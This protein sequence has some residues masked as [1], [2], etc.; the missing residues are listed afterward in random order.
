[1]AWKRLPVWISSKHLLAESFNN[2]FSASVVKPR[3]SG[4]STD[5]NQSH[6]S[7]DLTESVITG[8][9]LLSCNCFEDRTRPFVNCLICSL[10]SLLQVERKSIRS[11]NTSR[12]T[13]MNWPKSQFLQLS[14]QFLSHSPLLCSHDVVSSEQARLSSSH[15]K[16]I[17]ILFHLRLSLSLALVTVKKSPFDYLKMS[18][19]FRFFV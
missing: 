2:R 11:T 9:L 15:S 5:H 4:P 18:V 3:F 1:V 12:A 7:S 19:S 17:R 8:R 16:I 6:P 10:V 13:I 14:L